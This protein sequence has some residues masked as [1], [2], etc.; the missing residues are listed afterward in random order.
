M[1]DANQSQA[2]FSGAQSAPISGSQHEGGEV[3]DHQ[4]QQ[5]KIKSLQRGDNVDMQ[6]SAILSSSL[7]SLG[8]IGLNVEANDRQAAPTNQPNPEVLR[9]I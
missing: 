7:V 1:T 4:A 9:L 3:Q 8:Q 5:A 2:S 6:G